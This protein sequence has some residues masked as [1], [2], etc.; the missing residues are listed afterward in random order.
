MLIS[1]RSRTEKSNDKTCIIQHER[2]QFSLDNTFLLKK[3]SLK[4]KL[5]HSVLWPF[6]M[7]F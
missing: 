2:E 7:Y 4:V 3:K 6:A 1:F 5:V